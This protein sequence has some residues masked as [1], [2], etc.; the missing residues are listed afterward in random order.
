MHED[1]SP[2]YLQYNVPSHPHEEMNNTE[3]RRFNFFRR[4][5]V[6]G[7]LSFLNLLLT[8]QNS[9]ISLSLIHI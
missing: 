7:S 8:S 9:Y 1:K 6:R 4:E 5:D 3:N 2:L